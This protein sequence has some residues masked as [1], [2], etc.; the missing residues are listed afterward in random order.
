MVALLRSVGNA[1]A[2]ALGEWDLAEVALHLSQAWIIVPG[3]ADDDLS[4]AY[5]LLPERR[6]VAGASL[7]TDLWE[8]PGVTTTAVRA[9]PERDLT[10]LADRIEERAGAFL[11]GVRSR[12]PDAVHAWL[13]EGM[14]VQL[15]VLMCH[16]LNETIVHGYD[17]AR[18]AGRTWPIA[19]SHAALVVDGFL[20]PVFAGL[21]PRSLV[22]QLAAAGLCA[23]Y[24]IHVR[25]GGHHLF[26]FRDGALVIEP[27]GSRRVDCHIWADPTAFLL[28]AW[29]RRGQWPAVGRGQIVVW[30][31]RPW[32]GARF[33]SLLRNP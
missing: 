7:L 27:K 5:G 30:G 1:R 15:T 23:T 16:L 3:L 13:V 2:P 9:D 20:I 8:L 10:V 32:L 4:A 18:A 22:D 28:V 11:S 6:P 25:G 14:T 17:I 26:V 29:G 12:P 33:R 31:R 21:A 19:R 24:A